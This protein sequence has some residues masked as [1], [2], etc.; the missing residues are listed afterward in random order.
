MSEKSNKNKFSINE[1]FVWRFT[2]NVNSKKKIRSD[3]NLIDEKTGETLPLI[4]QKGNQ[5]I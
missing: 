1:E 4:L 3:A 5:Q 2:L